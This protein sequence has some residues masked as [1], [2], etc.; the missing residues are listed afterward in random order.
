MPHPNGIAPGKNAECEPGRSSPCPGR[1]ARKNPGICRSDAP[2]NDH[3]LGAAQSRRGAWAIYPSG[4]RTISVPPWSGRSAARAERQ[5]GDS[6]MSDFV[7]LYRSSDQAYREAAG[8]A[9]KA[10]QTL[11]R[12]QSWFKEMTEKGQLKNLGQPLDR[13]LGKVV[14]GKQKTVT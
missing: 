5:R 14:G 11:A 9:E 8:S 10:R 2:S 3:P 12:W 7:L 1:G 4:D 13:S 6:T